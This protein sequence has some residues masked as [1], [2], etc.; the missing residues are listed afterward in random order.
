VLNVLV[1][2][3]VAQPAGFDSEVAWENVSTDEGL[4]LEKR[5]VAMSSSPEYR[6]TAHSP[7]SVEK[8]CDL[9]FEWGTRGTDVPGL[10]ARKELSSAADERVVYDQFNAPVVS[11]RD[12]VV[13]VR[14]SRGAD[15]VCRVRYWA[16]NEKAPKLLDGWVRID[17]L[18]GGWTFIPRE[19]HTEIVYTQF[20][21]PGGSV[22]TIFAN[23]NQ[24]ARAVQTV[25]QA[26]AKGIAAGK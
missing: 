23:G 26:M 17:K 19:G 13:T 21:D 9:V 8:L 22:P 10:K 2:L 5:S 25:R 14:R 24:R 15:G 18:W 6:I 20:S 3:L 7:V 16:T 4:Q 12:Y 11:N 1:L